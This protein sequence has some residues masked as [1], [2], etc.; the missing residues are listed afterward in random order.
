MKSIDKLFERIEIR[1]S[2]KLPGIN[3]GL[4]QL[5]N[6]L[7]G[8]QNGELYVIAAR[9]GMGKTA[10]ALHFAEHAALNGAAVLFFSLEMA[11]YKLTDRMI[12]GRSGIESAKYHHAD[13]NN[14]DRD[15]LI[16]QAGAIA[17]M[18]IYFDEQSG[19]D[20]D[21]ISA[22]SR[23]AAR[24]KDIRM[25]IIDYLQ[26]IDMKERP[27]QT[28]D[29]AIGNVTRKL[30]QI[31]KELNVPI[32]LL[33]QLNRTVEGRA[34]KEPNLSDLRE[35]GNIEQDADVVLMLYRPAYYKVE[36]YENISSDNMLWILTKKYR[37]GLAINIGVKHNDS[38]TRFDN[39]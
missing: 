11:D 27:G 18:P 34:D 2:G 9:P 32:L 15:N 25:I 21:Y 22:T 36:T 16:N 35:S 20:I 13:V 10:L 8:W 24:K 28:R 3:T 26:L 6:M 5:N 30:K 12:I 31:S 39:Y 29:Q 33:S 38:L 19:I 17:N 4:R 7:A 14:L 37:N 1:E 23:I